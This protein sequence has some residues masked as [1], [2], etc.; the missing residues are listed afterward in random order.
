MKNYN[1]WITTVMGVGV[2]AFGCVAVWYDKI[3]WIALAAFLLIAYVLV[4]TKDPQWAKDLLKNI[5]K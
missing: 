3:P 5:I 1:N 2:L 4:K